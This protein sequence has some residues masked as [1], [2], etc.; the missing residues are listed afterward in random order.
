MYK[1]SDSGLGTLPVYYYRTS[2]SPSPTPSP[3][4]HFP[5]HSSS[6]PDPRPRRPNTLITENTFCLSCHPTCLNFAQSLT[7]KSPKPVRPSTSLYGNTEIF[8]IPFLRYNFSFRK[9]PFFFFYR[10]ILFFWVYL[11]QKCPL[12][13]VWVIIIICLR[14]R[15]AVPLGNLC[16]RSGMVSYS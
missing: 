16:L 11:R 15:F 4:P 5:H 1:N 14:V 9:F 10:E 2:R 7:I 13:C 6:A 8:T 3:L 12:L